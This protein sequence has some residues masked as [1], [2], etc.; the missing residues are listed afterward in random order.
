MLPSADL[1]DHM[2]SDPVTIGPDASLIDAVQLIIKHSISGLCVVDETHR[3]LGVLSEVDCLQ[4]FLNATYN[5]TSAGK[6]SEYMTREVDVARLNEN[7]INVASEM[8]SKNQRRRPVVED[9]KLIGQI[10]CR[11][12]LAAVNEFSLAKTKA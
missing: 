6:V 12:L 5:Q 8:M 1:K 10:T 3:L 11:H 4:G 9:T 7:I 2:S